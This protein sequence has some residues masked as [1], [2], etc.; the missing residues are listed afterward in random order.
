MILNYN[1]FR[2]QIKNGDV[3]LY[4]SAGWMNRYIIKPLLKTK[5]SHAGS[6]V[7]WNDRLMVMEAVPAGIRLMPLSVNVENYYG[8]V[9]LYRWSEQINDKKRNRKGISPEN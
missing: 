2:S 8:S 5:Y 1:D 4:D 3:L 7:W 9:D 6:A